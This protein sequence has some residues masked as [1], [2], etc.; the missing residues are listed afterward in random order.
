M[1]KVQT[2]RSHA[3]DATTIASIGPGGY[4]LSRGLATKV[5]S[6]QHRKNVMVTLQCVILVEHIPG[7]GTHILKLCPKYMGMKKFPHPGEYNLIYP[8]N[9]PI[10]LS[11]QN[12]T[13]GAFNSFP[14]CMK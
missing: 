6:I 14:N 5:C 13:L 3:L 4:I 2:F 11:F 7:Y 1:L 9:N 8:N 10:F 12:T